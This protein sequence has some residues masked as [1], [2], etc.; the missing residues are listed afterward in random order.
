MVGKLIW[1]VAIPLVSLGLQYISMGNVTYVPITQ[2]EYNEDTNNLTC[3]DILHMQYILME[4][5][6]SVP[7]TQEEYYEETNDEV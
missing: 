5:V 2:E 4:N 1:I 7:W 3:E 6:S